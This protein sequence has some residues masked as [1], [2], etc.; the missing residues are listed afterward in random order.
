MPIDPSIPLSSAQ[1]NP[2]QTAQLAGQRLQL[3]QARQGI[4]DQNALRTLFA[5]P[6]AVDAQGMPTQNTLARLTQMNPEEAMKLRGQ[7]LDLQ[8]GKA[9]LS[10]KQWKAGVDAAA[11]AKQLYDQQIDQGVSPAQAQRNAQVLYSQNM[12]QLAQSGLLSPDQ[13]AMLNPTFD[14]QRVASNMEMLKFR[15]QRR[16]NQQRI[17]MEGARLEMERQFHND[18]LGLQ[19]DRLAADQKA[20]EADVALR[21]DIMKRQ[22]E[23]ASVTRDLR[24]AQIDK[25]KHDEE[26]G[27]FVWN[28][29]IGDDGTGKQVP[30]MYRMSTTDAKAKPEFFPGVVTTPK[31]QVLTPEDQQHI[32]ETAK[33]IA[34]YQ[35]PPL[36]GYA[37]RSPYGQKVMARVAELNPTYQ[38]EQYNSRNKAVSAFSTGKQGDTV[39]FLNTSISH[40]DTLQQAVDAL[41]TGNVRA[42]NALTNNFQ[43][44]FGVAAP[45]NFETVKNIVGQEIVKAITGSSGAESDRQAAQNAFDKANSPEALV[46]AIHVVKALLGGQMRSLRKQY[47]DTTG[48]KNFDD[49]LTPEAKAALEDGPPAPAHAEPPAATS[50]AIPAIPMKDGAVDAKGLQVGKFYT[51]PNG[52]IGQWDGK[53]FRIAKP[54][55]HA[56]AAPARPKLADADIL[57]QAR[58]AIQAGADP[59]KIAAWLHAWG[60]APVA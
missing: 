39:R 33:M 28:P 34:N 29:G 21:R 20:R 54:E 50:N 5:Q 22:E 18:E 38:T 56:E 52:R 15:E 11:G 26:T 49:R 48:L 7:M 40:L 12:K 59:A 51:L 57:A 31:G 6:G 17:G 43:R 32:D 36:A 24:K 4:A 53:A 9:G 3:Q 60:V 42:L 27:K 10:E 46:G 14:P 2:L 45:T 8:L 19:R 35:M 55:K 23:D 44:E 58:Q 16:E 47:E 41:S 1:L 37:M 13:I 30:G 25:I